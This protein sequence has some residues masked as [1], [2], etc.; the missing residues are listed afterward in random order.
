M[1]NE[2]EYTRLDMPASKSVSSRR[3]LMNWPESVPLLDGK[4]DMIL[5]IFV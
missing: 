1:G 4:N 5:S 3:T 2:T